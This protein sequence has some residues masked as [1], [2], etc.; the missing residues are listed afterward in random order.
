MFRLEL[1]NVDL[2]KNTIPAIAEIIDE[3]VFKVDQ[4]GVNFLMPDRAMVAVVDLKIL[5]TAFDNYKVDAEESLGLNLANLVAVLKR[6]KGTDKMV[7]ESDGKSNRLKIT[8]Q[9][10]GTRVFEIPLIDIKAEKPPVDQLNFTTKVELQPG[11]FDEG[12]EDA[13]VIGDSVILEAADKTF[14]MYAKG[15]I[16]SA[17]LAIK[18][19]DKGLLGISTNGN[20]KARYPIEY[21]KKMSKVSKASKNLVLE[22][23]TD[24]PLRLSFTALDKMSLKFVLA[25]RVEE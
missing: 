8:I 10:S 24:Y 16:S 20:M 7:M 12:I 4:N 23:G 21:L 19:G 3:G 9:G 1:S 15:E 6:A 25:P 5:S 13:D 22:F 11:I 14:K 18:E 2:L 17:E